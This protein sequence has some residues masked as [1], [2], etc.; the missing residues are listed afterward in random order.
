MLTREQILDVQTYCSEHKVSLESR[1]GE[2]KID[3]SQFYRWQRKYRKEDEQGL[4]P[5]S[6]SFVQLM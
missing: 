5:E 6:G 2:L 1:L 3:K 4:G